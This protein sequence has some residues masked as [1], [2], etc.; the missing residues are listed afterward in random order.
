[1]AAAAE[2]A[3]ILKAVDK[4]TPVLK[5]VQTRMGGFAATIQR[6]SRMIG[7][8]MMA[9]GAAIVG[10]ALLATKSYAQ[11]GDE[12]AKMAKRTGFSTEALSELRYAAELSGTNLAGLEKSTRFLSGAIQ[13]AQDGMTT[14]IR[15]FERVGVDYKAL[16]G[17]KPE[18]QFLA[19][20][21]ALAGV[22]DES[23]KVATASDLLGSRMG[24]ALLPMM[25]DGVDAFRELRAEAHELGIVFDAEAATKAEALDDAFKKL[26]MSVM[27]TQ[28]A[29]GN[30]LMP[31]L[32]PL[33]NMLSG[34]AKW[35]SKWSEAHPLLSKVIAGTTIALGGLMI[36]VGALLVALPAINAGMALLGI[37]TIPMLITKITA[38]AS[39]IWG[40]VAAVVGLLAVSGPAGWA[41][42]A[43][44]VAIAGGAIY[45]LTK[46]ASRALST[47]PGMQ[48]GGIVPGPVGQ[49]TPIIAHGGERFLGAGNRGMGTTEIN[50]NVGYMLGDREDAEK[51]LDFI[52]SGLRS[53]IRI[54]TGGVVF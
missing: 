12:V 21:E 49:P 17:L 22:E 13:D 33:I 30:A 24:T 1:M 40:T 35:I 6:H 41:A 23:V 31:L 2:L 8:A 42:L 52:Q 54:S 44:G 18:Q 26:Q 20:M 48:Y 10:G 43:A 34:V 11:M 37:T 36:G 15:A 46:L 27:G 51:L 4:A 3:V 28:V 32:M 29:I 19:V 38:F 53:R 9:A 25:A 47:T 50:L 5:D 7:L 45:G 39:A 14:Y 16:A